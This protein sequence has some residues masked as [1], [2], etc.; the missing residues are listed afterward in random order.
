MRGFVEDDELDRLYAG[1]LAV[2]SASEYEGYGLPVAEGLAAGAPV[3]ASAIP[4]HREIAGDAAVYFDPGD[5]AGLAAAIKRVAEDRE[6]AARLREE[7]PRRALEIGADSPTWAEAIAASAARVTG[8]P[9][10]SRPQAGFPAAA[11]AVAGSPTGD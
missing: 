5:A 3:I 9:G 8:A 10:E 7:G 6:L 2:V 11:G 1:C 4:P